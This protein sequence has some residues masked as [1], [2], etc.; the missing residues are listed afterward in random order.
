[1]NNEPIYVTLYSE[2][3]EVTYTESVQY[4]SV[5][6]DTFKPRSSQ[7]DVGDCLE[8]SDYATAGMVGMSAEY[9]TYENPDT[10]VSMH[11]STSYYFVQPVIS[12]HTIS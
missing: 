8:N 7:I 4:H 5:G 6:P 2:E 11:V 3:S 1:M 12:A 9:Y 10:K